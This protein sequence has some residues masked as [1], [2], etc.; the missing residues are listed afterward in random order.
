MRGKESDYKDN[1]KTRIVFL[2]T[3]GGRFA[4]IYQLRRTGGLYLSDGIRIHVDPGPGA[5]RSMKV[6]SL[7]PAKTDAILVS[8]CHPDHYADAEM[9]IEGMVLGGFKRKGLIAASLSVLEGVEDMG[10]AIS[11]YHQNL[12]SESAVVRAGD[13]LKI[14][15]IGIEATPTL[16]GDPS[17]IGFKF[18]TSHGIISYVGD[19]QLFEELGEV[20]KGARILIINLTRPLHSRVVNHMCTEDAAAL[21]REVQPEISVVTHFG[22]K[23]LHEGAQKQV[24]YIQNET[25][26]RA[27]AAADLMQMEIGETIKILNTLDV[28]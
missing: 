14:G 8:H 20:H 22:M 24:E 7:D 19:T 16:H 12:P 11:R 3:G 5:L 23:L 6:L 21:I 27:F 26:I 4:T 13:S 10:P 28:G 17:G 15:N 9:L 2:G 18:I 25:G 1:H